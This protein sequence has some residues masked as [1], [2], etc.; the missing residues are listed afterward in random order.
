MLPVGEPKWRRRKEARPAEIVAAAVAVFAEKGFAAAKLDEIARRAGVSKGA[1][2][3]YF[4]TKE[5]LFRAVVHDAIA[6]NV[7]VVGKAALSLHA[8]FE[9]TVRAVL[10]RFATVIASRPE[11]AAVAKAVICESRNFPE[12]ARIWHDQVVSEGIK[13]LSGLIRRA[14]SQGEVIQGDARLFAFSFMGPLLL[15]VIWRETFEPIGA[16]AVDV[17]ALIDQH[18]GAMLGG[19]LERRS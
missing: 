11:V 3:L 18:V 4:E 15:S 9:V 13:L 6:P 17:E 10:T 19:M 5:D 16:P 12:L 8:P 1:L 2:Y 14:Q 7:E